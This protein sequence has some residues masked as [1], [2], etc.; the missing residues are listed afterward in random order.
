MKYFLSAVLAFVLASLSPIRSAE[1]S[2]GGA[3]PPEGED[4]ALTFLLTFDRL[5]TVADYA[6][7]KPTS[8]TF[9]DNLE[10]RLVPGFN[11]KNA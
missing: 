3:K 4:P 9:E 5:S 1:T 6:K 10:F 2:E 8:T 7:G 11:E